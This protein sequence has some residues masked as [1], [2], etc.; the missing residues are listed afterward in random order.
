MSIIVSGVSVSYGGTTAV[1]DVSLVIEAGRLTALVGP[2]GC[3][4]TSLL[5][6]IAGLERITAGSITIDGTAVADSRT[7]VPPERRNVGM[8]FQQGALFPHMTVWKNVMYGLGRSREADRTA[9]EAL[10]RVG[11]YDL[12]DRYP[13]QLSGGQQQRVALARAIAPSPAIVLLDEP[14]ASLDASLRMVLREEVRDVLEAASMTALLVTHDQDEALSIADVVA[15]MQ[16]GRILQTAAPQ[17]IYKA[18]ASGEVARI[19]GEG[20]LLE[21]EVREGR[22]SS[23]FGDLA[24]DAG[25]GPAMMLVRPEDLRVVDCDSSSRCS[26]ELQTRRYFGHDALDSVRLDDGRSVLVRR[27]PASYFSRGHRV[28][29]V[30]LTDSIAVFPQAGGAAT[31]HA[32][33]LG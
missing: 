10:E 1:D 31:A 16:Q 27:H 25:T 3:G 33:G 22:L 23:V 19:V 7:F 30:L 29:L 21:C 20:Q 17:T 6:A 5:R 2:S 26:G 8:V 14:F 13:D 18:P 12:R 28:A 15:V 4:K 24:T 32:A 11:M 9:R